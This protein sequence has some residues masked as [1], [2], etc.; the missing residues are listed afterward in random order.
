MSIFYMAPIP[1]DDDDDACSAD[2]LPWPGERHDLI[3]PEKDCDGRMVLRSSKHGLF[4]GCSNYPRCKGSHGAHP[5]GSPLGTPADKETKRARI[6]AHFFFDRLWHE[7]IMTRTEAYAML[8]EALHVKPIFAHIA[9]MD[10]TMCEVLVD[11]L[12][13][14]YPQII[15]VYDRLEADDLFEEAP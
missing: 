7:G 2:V 9:L 1:T 13:G 15:T 14:K 11:Y 4:Y 10:A 8:A 5:D 3:C 6:R 12:K